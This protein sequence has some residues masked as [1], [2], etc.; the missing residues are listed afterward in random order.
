MKRPHL[1]TIAACFCFFL[2]HTDLRFSCRVSDLSVWTLSSRGKSFYSLETFGLTSGG[3]CAQTSPL[4]PVLG[5]GAQPLV[6]VVVG[7]TQTGW[8]HGWS[9]RVAGC[10]CVQRCF[11]AFP[12]NVHRGP[13]WPSDGALA[14]KCHMA[15]FQRA[16]GFWPERIQRE[17]G[18]RRDGIRE[19]TTWSILS[20][21]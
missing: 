16:L 17:G 9:N 15:G 18:D 1:E 7:C 3:T 8:H 11:S 14:A 4:A 20:T 10:W 6:V 5:V 13:L 2:C 21:Q 19:E 12:W